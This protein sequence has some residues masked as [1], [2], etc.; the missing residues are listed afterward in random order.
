MGALALKV[1]EE[2]EKFKNRARQAR[3]LSRK[4]GEGR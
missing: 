1:E 4:A 2:D 3:E